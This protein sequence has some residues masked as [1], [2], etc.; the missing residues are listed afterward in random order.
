MRKQIGN[1]TLYCGDALEIIPK[2]TGVDLIVTDPPYMM[3]LLSDKANARALDP[4]R[5]YRPEAITRFRWSLVSTRGTTK[6]DNNGNRP[7]R[8]DR[9]A[10]A[11]RGSRLRIGSCFPARH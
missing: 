5:D 9:E 3:T 2:I 4:G 1:A 11:R 10:T 8:R 7:S 6:M